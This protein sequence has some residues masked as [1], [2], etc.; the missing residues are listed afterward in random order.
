MIVVKI[1]LWP[2]GHENHP[3]KQE[4]GRLH[5]T[6]LGNHP[7]ARRRGNYGIRVMRRGSTNKV[8]KEGEV[9]DYPR[10]SYTIWELVKRALNNVYGV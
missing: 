3:R 6:N 4:L 7:N 1:E 2:G 9:L 5:I 8:L 10:E